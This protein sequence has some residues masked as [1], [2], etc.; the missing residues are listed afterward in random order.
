DPQRTRLRHR[1]RAGGSRLLSQPRAIRH[2]ELAF[3][4]YR[5]AAHGNHDRRWH[6]RWPH[7][8]GD[9]GPRGGL[10]ARAA[11][12]AAASAALGLAPAAVVGCV[13]TAG[14]LMPRPLG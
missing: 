9:C 11:E 8:L 3:R 12:P 2:R 5:T 1:R 7:V 14:V 10:L 13:M 6:R 4:R